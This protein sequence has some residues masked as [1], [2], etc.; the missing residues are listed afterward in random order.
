MPKGKYD[1]EITGKIDRIDLSSDGQYFMI[2]DYKTGSAAINLLEVYFGLKL[3]LLT[4]LLVAKN[5]LAKTQGHQVL[6][7][8]MLYFFLKNP[9]ISVKKKIS[10]KELEKEVQKVFEMPGWVLADPEVIT[11]IDNASNFVKVKLKNGE[12][13]TAATNLKKVKTMDE[14]NILMDYVEYKL[15]KTGKEILSGIIDASPQEDRNGSSCTYCQFR[16]FCG[17]D[18]KLPGY[19]TRLLPDYNPKDDVEIME[20]MAECSKEV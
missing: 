18:S 4:Y 13:D 8:G 14:F 10:D 3:Q 6:P 9:L 1:L 16:A 7:A 17:Y 20:K 11:K 5:L 12:L 2:I 15:Q 19:R